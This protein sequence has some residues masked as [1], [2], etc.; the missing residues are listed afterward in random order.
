MIYSKNGKI[1]KID[2]KITCNYSGLY[3]CFYKGHSYNIIKIDCRY[4]LGGRDYWYFYVEGEK[5][6]KDFKQIYNISEND[7]INNFLTN[8]QMRKLKLEKIQNETTM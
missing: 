2:D 8:I 7:V 4:G 6:Y 3:P 5:G 1:V